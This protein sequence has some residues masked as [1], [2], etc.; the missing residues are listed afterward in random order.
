[1]MNVLPIVTTTVATWE[2]AS[3]IKAVLHASAIMDMKATVLNAPTLMNAATV[4]ATNIPSA[5]TQLDH[6]VASAR[7]DMEAELLAHATTLMNANQQ[8]PVPL[9]QPVPIWLETTAVTVTTVTPEMGSTLVKMLTSARER[10]PVTQT[11]PVLTP[12]AL[13]HVHATTDTSVMAVSARLLTKWL[14]SARRPV[15]THAAMVIKE[16]DSTAK[17]LTSVTEDLTIVTQTLAAKTITDHSPAH[18]MMDI[19]VMVTT[20]LTLMNALTRHAMSTPCVWIQ[21]VVLLV[22]VPMGSPVMVSTVLTLMNAKSHLHV[23]KMVP[24]L[25]PLEATPVHA[26]TVSAAMATHAKT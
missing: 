9:M 15:N 17:I 5:Q 20:A 3:T 22:S 10:T 19:V 24:A 26:T 14:F 1:L 21:M 23:M 11:L 4:H 25:T 8:M 6:L 16:L 18:A 13:T 12:P 2:N 7:M